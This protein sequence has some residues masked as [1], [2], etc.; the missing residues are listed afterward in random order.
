MIQINNYTFGRM[1]VSGTS[2]TSDLIIYPDG[3]VQGNW[4]RQS[5]HF[6]VQADITDLINAKPAEIIVGTGA[7]GR[8]QVDPG[9]INALA[10]EGIGLEI[11]PTGRAVELFN[12]KQG[13]GQS[14]GACFHLTC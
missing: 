7:S 9:L 8:M 14:P 4:F 11:L 6:L 3:R 5:G 1:S 2:H 13:Q 10:A 12:R